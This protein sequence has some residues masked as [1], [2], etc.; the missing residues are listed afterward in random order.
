MS[1]EEAKRYY[2]KKTTRILITQGFKRVVP[3][4]EPGPENQ[5]RIGQ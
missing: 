1:G 5:E 4:A 2:K 3:D